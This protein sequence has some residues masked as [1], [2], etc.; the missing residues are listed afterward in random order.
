MSK[1]SRNAKYALFQFSLDNS[2][3]IYKSCTFGEE[4]SVGGT[5]EVNYNWGKERGKEV[6]QGTILAMAGKLLFYKSSLLLP[7]LVIQFA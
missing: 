6:L 4:V 1:R 5:Y 7:I 3:A 2:T